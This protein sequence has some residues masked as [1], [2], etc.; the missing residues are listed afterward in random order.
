MTCHEMILNNMQMSLQLC[1]SSQLKNVSLSHKLNI[2]GLNE[3]KTTLD[4]VNYK[5]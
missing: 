3:K 1:V 5:P 4:H 2:Y